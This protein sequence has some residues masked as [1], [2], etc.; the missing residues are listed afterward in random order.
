MQAYSPAV[1]PLE[2]RVVEGWERF[3]LGAGC[4]R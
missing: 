3:L 1:V 2:S 4:V